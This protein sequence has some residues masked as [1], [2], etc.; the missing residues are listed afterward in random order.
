MLSP[1]TEAFPFP[2][3]WPSSTSGVGCG[4]RPAAGPS[5]LEA[6]REVAEGSAQF[7][8][9]AKQF[10]EKL[11]ERLDSDSVLVL[12]Q[13]SGQSSVGVGVRPVGQ[14]A[15][16]FAPDGSLSLTPVLRIPQ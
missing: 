11:E 2:L 14:D 7:V 1:P 13:A 4:S 10:S 3:T 15:P 5:C 9:L 12:V 8:S 16:Q 6:A